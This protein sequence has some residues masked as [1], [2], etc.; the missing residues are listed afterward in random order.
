M[1]IAHS[2]DLQ[3]YLLLKEGFD[4]IPDSILANVRSISYKCGGA[5]RFNILERMQWKN[6]QYCFSYK[7]PF[8]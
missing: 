2:I 6:T 1:G 4:V 8:I 7:M 5:Q 3:K